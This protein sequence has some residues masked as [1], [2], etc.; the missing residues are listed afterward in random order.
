[1]PVCVFSFVLQ[2]VQ[3]AFVFLMEYRIS[4]PNIV[5]TGF[6]RA[7]YQRCVDAEAILKKAE[8]QQLKSFFSGLTDV[9]LTVYTRTHIY[10]HIY[11]LPHIRRCLYTY[12]YRYIDIA[13]LL[14]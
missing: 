8:D 7:E 14:I 4:A 9:Q 1:V 10:N 6:P 3:W 5:L 13:T 11:R 2:P 12:R